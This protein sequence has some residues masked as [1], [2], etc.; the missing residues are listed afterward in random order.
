MSRL[1]FSN[2]SEFPR[3]SSFY[4]STLDAAGEA[5]VLF[6]PFPNY[7]HARE[8][9][10]S[11]E[12]ENVLR[13]VVGLEDSAQHVRIVDSMSFKTAE[14]NQ[15]LSPK[16]G[17]LL[18]EPSMHDAP[19]RGVRAEFSKGLYKTIVVGASMEEVAYH[20]A[21]RHGFSPILTPIP[22]DGGRVWLNEQKD[23]VVEL[24][25]ASQELAD[26]F[27]QVL[28]KIKQVN[29]ELT[30]GLDNEPVGPSR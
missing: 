6:G 18:R 11:G 15:E 8:L 22:R 9:V 20:L 29:P 12:V 3:E 23:A 14:L 21:I 5:R 4:I 24:R 1:R 17:V 30:K 2:A 26:E 27:N 16:H 7:G 10:S 13:S 19:G 25:G 28:S